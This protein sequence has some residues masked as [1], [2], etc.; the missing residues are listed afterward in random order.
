MSILDMSPR[1]LIM[2]PSGTPGYWVRGCVADMRPW[3]CF[4]VFCGQC[5]TLLHVRPDGLLPTHY[6]LWCSG[7]GGY[8][9][10]S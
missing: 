1:D 7:Y 2:V 9:E 8:W 3:Y 6:G 4:V 10:K 5:G